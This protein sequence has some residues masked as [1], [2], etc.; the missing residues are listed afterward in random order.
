[1]P[2][3]HKNVQDKLSKALDVANDVLEK[4]N[5]PVVEL[6]KT[7]R[8]DILEKP[9]RFN[10][11]TVHTQE[12]Y[13]YARKIYY[14][15]IERGSQAITGILELAEESEH[16]RTYEVAGQLIKIISEVAT[17]LMVLQEKMKILIGPNAFEKEKEEKETGDT[18]IFTGTTTELLGMVNE[19]RKI[20]K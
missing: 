14:G 5:K 20:K 9:S 16:P 3:S 19:A 2:R 1:M 10:E 8:T 18:F 17:A 13:E 4:S 11:P 15:L 6:I 7:K 12:D